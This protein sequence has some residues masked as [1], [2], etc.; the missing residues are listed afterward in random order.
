M[1]NLILK[2]ILSLCLASSACLAHLGAQ[3]IIIKTN[4]ETINCFVEEISQ[5]EIRYRKSENLRGPFYSIDVQEVNKI[6]YEN[7][8][9][10]EFV[11]TEESKPNDAEHVE[12]DAKTIEKTKAD[13]RP[14]ENTAKQELPNPDDLYD[15]GSANTASQSQETN[16]VPSRKPNGITFS[17]S[18]LG[19]ADV[20]SGGGLS[21]R[22]ERML[23]RRF[24][25]G[26][27]GYVLSIQPDEYDSGEEITVVMLGSEG[28]FYFNPDS[29]F[30]IFAGPEILAATDDLLG[31][32]AMANIGF[33]WNTT[34]RFHLFGAAGAGASSG[35][36]SLVKISGGLG[37]NF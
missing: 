34:Q 5:K 11:K 18:V 32:V 19:A 10:E 24:S 8:K 25:V 3:D 27:V 22:Y 33:R 37:F 36:Y 31:V 12:E 17:V 21:A 13:Q 1:K 14:A 7:G 20:L 28:R 9:V 15:N 23:G 26:G 4:G 35:E 30:K 16:L 29:K 6:V 2:S